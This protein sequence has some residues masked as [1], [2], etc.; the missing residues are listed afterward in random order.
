[1]LMMFRGFCA[2]FFVA[3]VTFS[4]AA[5]CWLLEMKRV[6]RQVVGIFTMSQLAVLIWLVAWMVLGGGSHL[7]RVFSSGVVIALLVSSLVNFQMIANKP[8][9]GN[10]T[11]H[12]SVGYVF[13][14]ISLL[15]IQRLWWSRGKSDEPGENTEKKAPVSW[16]RVGSLVLAV[17]LGVF[18]LEQSLP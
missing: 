12:L 15:A 4:Y 17:L 2:I 11:F 9:D 8:T 14:L 6:D 5:P 3:L 18:C 16:F 10:V 1:M 7:Q 13:L